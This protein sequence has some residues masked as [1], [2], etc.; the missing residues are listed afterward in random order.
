MPSA[1]GQVLPNGQLLPWGSDT[2]IG[3]KTYRNSDGHFAHGRGGFVDPGGGR[4]GRDVSGRGSRG[5]PHGAGANFG[6]GASGRA[7]RGG[8]QAGFAG[9]PWDVP[10]VHGHGQGRGRGME[11]GEAFAYYGH[12]APLGGVGY[13]G[14]FNYLSEQHPVDPVLHQEGVLTA[15]HGWTSHGGCMRGGIGRRSMHHGGFHR[16]GGGWKSVAMR[17]GMRVGHFGRGGGTLGS[18]RGDGNLAAQIQAN[19][20]LAAQLA[21]QQ[22]QEIDAWHEHLDGFAGGIGVPQ[23]FSG[24]GRGGFWRGQG[25]WGRGSV[26]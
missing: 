1:Y 2:P 21:A 16:G 19:P 5:I 13:T 8:V 14:R 18:A 17:S 7:G 4:D 15:E 9:V 3:P 11:Q 22:R 12:M 20:A 10:P 26:F 6:R 23:H 24:E 25:S